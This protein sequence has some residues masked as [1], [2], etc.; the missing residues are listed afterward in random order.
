VFDRVYNGEIDTWDYQWGFANMVEGR[1][2]VVPNVNLVS[3]IGFGPDAT[4]T[5]RDAP[6]ANLP[7]EAMTFPLR[8]PVGMFQC[9]ELDDRFFE[10][11]EGIPLH[12]RVRGKVGRMLA[13][14]VPGRKA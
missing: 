4:H 1:L 8:H 7:T 11:F 5:I 3:N 9:R 10:T 6:S 14:A 13:G 2:S 12:R